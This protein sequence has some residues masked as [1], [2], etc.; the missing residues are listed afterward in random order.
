MSQPVFNEM[1]D[2]FYER[3]SMHE[4]GYQCDPKDRGNWTSGK[5]G[6]GKLKGTNCG[7]S[8]MTY[9]HLDIKN[10]TKKEIKSI[11]YNDWYLAGKLYQFC[12]PL[13]YQMFDA[14]FLSG[15]RAANKMLQ[16][17]VKVK[18]D[19]IIGKQTLAAAS[20]MSEADKCIRFLCYRNLFI[21]SL[22]KFKT[23]GK[24]WI[25]RVNNCGLYMALDNND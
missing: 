1:F 2:K 15:T 13:Q 21:A 17:A 9:P 5:I 8:A 7:I 6:V 16:R 12:E 25:N 24:G 3:T 10:L 23:Y 20:E 11:Y 4:G 19:G 14:A 22:S 18:D